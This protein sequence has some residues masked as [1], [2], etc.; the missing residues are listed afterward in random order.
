M[1]SAGALFSLAASSKDTTSGEA[2]AGPVRW[3]T[4]GAPL[5]P[6]D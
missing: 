2:A 1:R 6:F 5:I 3:R 4:F